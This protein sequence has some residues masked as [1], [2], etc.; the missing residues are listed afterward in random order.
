MGQLHSFPA[1]SLQLA[2]G[3]SGFRPRQSPEPIG[4]DGD[5]ILEPSPSRTSFHSGVSLLASKEG[6]TPMILS[7]QNAGQLGSF[8][9]GER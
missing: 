9:G 4:R 8:L 3:K 2:K 1:V 6:E 5:I 7:S